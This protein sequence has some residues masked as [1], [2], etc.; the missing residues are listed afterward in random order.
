MMSDLFYICKFQ[1]EILSSVHNR[2]LYATVHISP[3]KKKIYIFKNRILDLPFKSKK[4]RSL[5]ITMD[6]MRL[7]S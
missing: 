2:I 6:Y 7:T 3:I 1:L 4:H 5:V